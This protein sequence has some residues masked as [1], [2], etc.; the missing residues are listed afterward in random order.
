MRLHQCVSAC[1]A[2]SLLNKRF[3]GK[4]GTHVKGFS[5][6]SFLALSSLRLQMYLMLT[7]VDSFLQRAHSLLSNTAEQVASTGPGG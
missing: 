1:S 2:K 3:W 5:F 6:C 7:G 4:A